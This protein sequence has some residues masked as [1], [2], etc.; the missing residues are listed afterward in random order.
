MKN[1]SINCCK[2]IIIAI[3]LNVCAISHVD[4]QSGQKLELK[5]IGQIS[6]GEMAIEIR[7]EGNIAFVVDYSY[8]L[9]IYN[10]SDLTNPVELSHYSEVEAVHGPFLGENLVYLSDQTAG[11]KIIN[12]SDPV[13]PE[14]VGQFHDGGEV[15]GVSVFEDFAFLSDAIDGLEVVNVSDP[16]QPTEVSQYDEVNQIISVNINSDLAYVSVFVPSSANILRILNISDVHNLEEIAHYSVGDDEIFCIDFVG[17]VA[18]M[19]C[20]RVE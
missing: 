2:I 6:T 5:E 11:L 15:M 20:L 8:G 12:V 16:T 14:Q 19:T 10:I 9:R 18:Y 4:A 1:N 7:V 13:N 17:D 3:V